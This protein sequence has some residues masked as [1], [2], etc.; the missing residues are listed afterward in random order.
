MFWTADGNEYRIQASDF[1]DRQTDKY[2]VY[3]PQGKTLMVLGGRGTTRLESH[4]GNYDYKVLCATSSGR[5]DAG[6]PLVV[7]KSIY[8][9]IRNELQHE[10][11]ICANLRGFYSPLPLNYEELVLEAPGSELPA[12]L[13]SWLANSLH[14]PRY[15]LKVDSRL[16]IEKRK[17]DYTSY[18]MDPI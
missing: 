4:L 2:I 18:R 8:E 16:L 15:C 14:I 3:S 10:G 9:D 5:C 11:S 12:K 1:I 17:S 6:I 7:S 13:R